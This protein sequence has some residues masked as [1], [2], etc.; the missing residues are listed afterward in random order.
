MVKT[1]NIKR[2]L[3]YPILSFIDCRNEERP[4][5]YVSAVVSYVLV[6]ASLNSLDLSITL[7]TYQNK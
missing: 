4:Y 5:V 3:C 2:R 1:I 6:K 7:Y